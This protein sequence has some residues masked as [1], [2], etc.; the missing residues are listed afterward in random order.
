MQALGLTPYL[1]ARH[2]GP[3]IV[4]VHQPADAGFELQRFV[5]ALKVRGVLISNFHNTEAPTFRVGCIGAVTPEDMRC[6]VRAMGEALEAMG[7]RR[8]EAA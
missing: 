3:V 1:E 5:D 6:A 7:I 2:Q 4:T 8:R